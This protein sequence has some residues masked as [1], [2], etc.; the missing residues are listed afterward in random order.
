MIRYFNFT[1][2]MRNKS[3]CRLDHHVFDRRH[4]EAAMKHCT[5]SLHIV[6]L[7]LMRECAGLLIQ[8]VVSN[9]CCIA[10]NNFWPKI[11]RGKCPLR[12]YCP[13]TQEFRPI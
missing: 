10:P 9:A 13:Q 4:R 6:S 2:F 7:D 1:L 11:P 12:G 5:F 8:N 3:K